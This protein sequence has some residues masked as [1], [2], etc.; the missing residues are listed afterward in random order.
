MAEELILTDPVQPPTTTKYR[1]SSLTLDLDRVVSPGVTGSVEITLVDN[2]GVLLNHQYI[3]AEAESMIRQLN[4]ANLTTKSMHKRV[5]EKLAAD[6]VIPGTVTGTPDP[7]A[8]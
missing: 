6:G 5:L 8:A 3:G 2:N 1:V 4:T 7:P